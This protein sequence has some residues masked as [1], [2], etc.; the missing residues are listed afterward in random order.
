MFS[1]FKTTQIGDSILIRTATPDDAPAILRYLNRISAESDYLSFGP[2][3]FEPT[4]DQERRTLKKFQDSD[5]DLYLVGIIDD[6]IVSTL[7]YSARNRKRVRHCGEFGVT[8]LKE[9]WGQGIAG[10]MLDELIIWARASGVVRKINL[11]VRTDNERAIRLYEW[12]GFEVEGTVRR[13]FLI[14]GR[15]YDHHLM[16]LI[17]D[18]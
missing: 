13:D 17:V 3:E 18:P 5:C 7:H 15:F 9:Y 2:G 16:G 12:K 14:D 6:Q 8:V 11:R 4:E 10:I 1:K